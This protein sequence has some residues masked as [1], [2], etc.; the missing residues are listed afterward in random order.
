M[1]KGQA[2]VELLVILA[3]SMVLIGLVLFTSNNEMTGINSNKANSDAKNTVEKIAKTAEDV[4]D[5]G[6][7]TKKQI[8]I[9]IPSG[10]DETKTSIANNTVRINING[11]DII[12]ESKVELTGSI[13]T[14]KG[15]YWIWITSHQG[16]V[17]I[18]DIAVE[19]DKESVYSTIAQET[20]AIEN[21][22]VINNTT[23][24]AD[25][26]ASYTWGNAEV[27][28][29]LSDNS[30]VVLADSNSG[31][32]LN[33][34]SSS[35]AVG[36]YTGELVFDIN[37]VDGT[38]Q[39]VVPITVEVIVGGSDQPIMIFPDSWNELIEQGQSD[40]N[41]FQVCNTTSGTLTNIVF[42]ASSGDAG[43]WVGP[44]TSIDSLAGNTCEQ[45][46]VTINVPSGASNNTGTVTGSDGTN[47]D[48]ISLNVSIPSMA[49]NFNFSWDTALFSS[50]TRLD[51]WTI[52][53]TSSTSNIVISE[54]I[55]WDWNE[56]DLDNAR[57]NR[58][59][60]NGSSYW[61]GLAVAGDLIDV[62][63]FTI[64]TS[65]SYS[66]GNRLQF[67][68]NV[69]DDGEYFRITF[70][71]L[72]GSSYTTTTYYS[73]DIVAPIILLENPA[74]GFTSTGFSVQFDYSVNDVD[75][76]IAYCE[77][78]I[79]GVV[80]QTDNTIIE[81]ITQSFNKTFSANGTYYWDVNC[82]DDSVNA[83]KGSSNENRSIKINSTEPVIIAFDVFPLNNWGTGSGWLYSWHH[84]GDSVLSTSG[85]PYSSP[86]H[87]RL[88]RAT[89]YADRAVDLSSYSN[90]RLE[91]W[92]KVN[93]FEA[94]DEAYV[95]VSP[96]DIHWITIKTFTSADS[97]NSYH[98][99]EFDLN[100]YTLSS[101]FW[102][103][104]D[105]GMN[106]TNDYFYIDDINIVQ[107]TP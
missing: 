19:T 24:D 71:F 54:M 75:S 4:F 72:D 48:F 5:S 2:S 58:I 86:R 37:T 25:V 74:E 61:T 82:V 47:S 73:S 56:T 55:V 23:Q 22:K 50:T 32:D 83:N 94:L 93:S 16:Y 17:S 79:D 20:N 95:L 31:I 30:F 69:R 88:R 70:V 11:T 89:G 90:P 36:N 67:N 51:N 26:D 40:S 43:N 80:D 63:D 41:D 64:N 101:E 53:N 29:Q 34:I 33:F 96:D 106:A 1:N 84:T 18:G 103:A 52:E 107:R 102:I 77:L 9:S 98:F 7:G 57:L 49:D 62:T 35:S 65:N 14:E 10:V 6:P 42:T 21:I 78:I 38:K 97:D 13:P 66:T 39:I 85:T 3:V 100:A 59:R 27:S 91:F 87:L 60:F 105:A 44:I 28:M 15:S 46:T 99:Y 12:A 81:G 68:A 92:A 8:Y 76:G 104:F 45:I